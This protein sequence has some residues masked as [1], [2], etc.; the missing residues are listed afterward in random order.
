MPS[1]L[2]EPNV[3]H[4]EAIPSRPVKL[5]PREL[6]ADRRADSTIYLRSPHALA[7]YPGKLTDAMSFR[8]GHIGQLDE[9][10]MRGVLGAVDAT[11][12]AMNITNR[13]RR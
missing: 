1:P 2:R 8:I 13:G 12:R 11:C 3:E 6:V 4:A 7:P 10:V 9:T 5:G